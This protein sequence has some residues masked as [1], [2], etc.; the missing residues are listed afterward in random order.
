[1]GVGVVAVAAA[2]VVLVRHGRPGC[3]RH[4]NGLGGVGRPGVVVG[5]W[6]SSRGPC[7]PGRLGY[8]RRRGRGGRRRR[9]RRRGRDVGVYL[10]LKRFH[11]SGIYPGMLSAFGSRDT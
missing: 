11:R 6:W 7:G 10:V 4:H 2:A 5:S 8:L 1:M 3:P 9:R